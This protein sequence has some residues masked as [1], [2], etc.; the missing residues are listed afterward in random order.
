[1]SIAIVRL[2]WINPKQWENQDLK[3]FFLQTPIVMARTQGSHGQFIIHKA[4]YRDNI[5]SWQWMDANDRRD[6]D[7]RTM[8]GGYNI[9]LSYIKGDTFYAYNGIEYKIL[10]VNASR[11]VL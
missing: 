5:M 1:M 8:S 2:T 6:D 10:E 3:E 9:P 7:V 4:I 11:H